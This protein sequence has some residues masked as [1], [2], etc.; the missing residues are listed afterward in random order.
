MFE[1]LSRQLQEMKDMYGDL[2]KRIGA[3]EENVEKKLTQKLKC[4]L[5]SR[6]EEV[7]K[8]IKEQILGVKKEVDSQ[9]KAIKPTYSE[10]VKNKANEDYLN[11]NVLI[12]NPPKR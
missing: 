9:I 5:D 2:T 3:I 4:T 12:K 1:T 8:E 11:S 7:R 10:T 6:L